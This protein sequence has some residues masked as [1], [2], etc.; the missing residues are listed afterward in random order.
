M[1]PVLALVAA[2]RQSAPLGGHGWHVLEGA[3]TLVLTLGG[4][5]I[6]EF[7]QG[8]RRRIASSSEFGT[9]HSVERDSTVNDPAR[10]WT[11]R[12]LLPLIVIAGGGAAAVH[13]AVMPEHFEESWLYGTFFAVLATFQVAYSGMLMWRPSRPLLIAGAVANAAVILLWLFTRTIAVPLG[14]GAGRTEDFGGL[15]ILSSALEFVFVGG[16]LVILRQ[17]AA[18]R[19]AP[20]RTWSP[21]AWIAALGTVLAVLITVRLAPAS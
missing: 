10:R 7:L 20:P 15:D 3:A 19:S 11:R 9:A 5:W 1:A 16:A 18:P 4:I 14:P 13:F 8:R 21:P 6:A 12:T 2:S 17:Q